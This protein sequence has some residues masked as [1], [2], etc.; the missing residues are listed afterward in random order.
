MFWKDAYASQ[1]I[2]HLEAELKKRN[3]EIEFL[4]G[5]LIEQEQAFAREREQL[6]NRLL[7]LPP[8]ADVAATEAEAGERVPFQ[9]RISLLNQKLR[10]KQEEDYQ[11]YLAAQGNRDKG[12]DQFREEIKAEMAGVTE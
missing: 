4:N 2:Q 3:E 11:N 6:L 9:S 1:F 10:E 5:R 7:G 12:L 8:Q